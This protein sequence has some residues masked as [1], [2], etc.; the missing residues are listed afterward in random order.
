V[1]SPRLA[2]ESSYAPGFAKAAP[3]A[4][5]FDEI[6]VFIECA[7]PSQSKRS[8]RGANRESAVLPVNPVELKAKKAAQTKDLGAETEKPRFRKEIT[9]FQY[10][11]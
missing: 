10:E 6:R 7:P 11:T 2:P 1:S 8:L 9:A 5:P 4:E 3:K